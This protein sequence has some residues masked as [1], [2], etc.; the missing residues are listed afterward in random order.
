M[1]TRSSVLDHIEARTLT[2]LEAAAIL[3]VTL[4]DATSEIHSA[5]PVDEE[6]TASTFR[7]LQERLP[8]EMALEKALATARLPAAYTPGVSCPSATPASRCR[9]SR[10]VDNAKRCQRP[11]R[12]STAE[13]NSCAAGTRQFDVLAGELSL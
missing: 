4:D 3:G 11:H 8:K 13:D 1:T 5:I 10:V 6:G 9:R 7:N 2:E 12:P